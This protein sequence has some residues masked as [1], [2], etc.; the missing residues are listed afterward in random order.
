MTE[1]PVVRALLLALAATVAWPAAAQVLYKLT[2]RQGRVTYSDSEPRNFDGTVVRLEADTAANIM[3]SAKKGESAPRPGPDSGIGEDRRHVREDLEKKLRAAQARVDAVR[4]AKAEGGE[5]LPEE[6]QTIQ[7][8]RAPLG[9]GQ[10]PP[11]PNCFAA[12]DPN[13]AASLNCPTRVPLD[14]FYQ[15]QKQLEEELRRAEEELALAE[16][17]YRRGTD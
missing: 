11:N 17:A 10:A 16:R 15:R 5:P 9:P 4:K 3:P 2:D 8:R 1:R 6:M 12:V 13:G 7:H 14:A